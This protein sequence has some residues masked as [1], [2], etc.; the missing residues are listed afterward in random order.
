ML[1]DLHVRDCIPSQGNGREVVVHYNPQFAGTGFHLLDS[2]SHCM[3]KTKSTSVILMHE[4]GLSSFSDA[5]FIH[6]H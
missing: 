2:L 5:I 4:V 6:D 3:S 1:V